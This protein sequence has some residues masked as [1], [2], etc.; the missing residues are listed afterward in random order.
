MDGFGERLRAAR[1][2]LGLTQTDLAHRTGVSVRAIRDLENGRVRT[3]HPHTEQ[4]L[5]AATGLFGAPPEVVELSV[6]ALGP[7]VVERRGQPV[8]PG[9]PMHALVL[10]V[11][12]LQPGEPI[13]QDELVDVLWG[14]NPPP[15]CVNLLHTYVSRL[16]QRLGG[17][18][19][20]RD[21]S[22]YVLSP[23]AS[24]VLEFAG[25]VRRASAAEGDRTTVHDLT[26]AALA[27]W[28]GEVLAGSHER[29]RWHPAAIAVAQ[30]RLSTA[31]LNAATATTPREHAAVAAR[32]LPLS[33]VEPLHEELHAA[34]IR[35]LS[36]SGQRALAATC[37]TDIS[38]RL[39]AELDVA[40]GVVLRA[41]HT[42]LYSGPAAL[43]VPAARRTPAQLPPLTVGFTGREAD[44][45]AM[46]EMRAEFVAQG[47]TAVLLVVGTPGVGKTAMAV[48]WA[49]HQQAAHPDGSLHVDLRGHSGGEPVTAHDALAGLLRALGATPQEVPDA[50]EERAGLY[51]TLLAE[52]RVLVVLDNAATADQVRPLLPGAPASTV[53]VTSRNR[54][55][56]LL[57]RDGARVLVLD[58]LTPAAARAVLA[59]QL[60]TARAAAEPAAVADLAERCAR[61][62]LALRISAA[63][64][65]SRPHLSVAEHAE[66]L[67]GVASLDALAIDDDEDA[68]VRASFTLSY[69]RLR[70]PVRAV[71]RLLGILPGPDLT[72]ATVAAAQGAEVRH[73]ASALDLLESAHLVHQRSAGRYS[74]HDLLRL[75]AA[76]RC[77]DEDSAEHRHDAHRRVLLHSLAHVH[78][79]RAVL[80]RSMAVLPGAEPHLA[81]APEF[82]DGDRARAWL[83]AERP[84]LVAA[85]TGLH[86]DHPELVCALTDVLRGHFTMG[87][88]LS[89]WARAAN[90]ALSAAERTGDAAA[91]AALQLSLGDLSR[92]RG[93]TSAALTHLHAALALVRR[94]PW[95]LGEAAVLNNMGIVFLKNGELEH[96]AA[97]FEAA[98]RIFERDGEPQAQMSPLGNLG[99]VLRDSGRLRAAVEICTRS[100]E[101]QLRLGSRFGQGVAAAN[102][103][104][105]LS[106]V[107]ELD[108]A[109]E[110]LL[111]GLRLSESHGDLG[112]EGECSRRLAVVRRRAGDLPEALRLAEH[113]FSLA[114]RVGDAIDVAFAL[115]TLG[116]VFLALGR[117]EDATGA[118]TRALAVAEEAG[119]PYATCEALTGL[120]FSTADPDPA[121]AA[122]HLT[123]KSGFRDLAGSALAALAHAHLRAGALTDAARYARDAVEVHRATG[124]RYAQARAAEV[125]ERAR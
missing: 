35:A 77:A 123:R 49:H 70:A 96:A 41:A 62:P 27:R 11:L 79:A 32:L 37:Y 29:L 75:Y 47:V 33:T 105:A 45:T 31:L 6:G 38:A 44:M 97:H 80:Y 26:T 103:G 112:T 115:N 114:E 56:G 98:L 118:H 83:D 51:R 2:R 24:D 100:R 117:T 42:A 22:G 121:S 78:Q 64:L 92:L 119:N 69:R 82:A 15:S 48:Q 40:P 36:S 88:H 108:R 7:L 101:L 113:A 116:T 10:G 111:D 4:V 46:D 63:I 8:D 86:E 57:A 106:E 122:L 53:V 5:A 95:T 25:L 91:Q 120:S 54:L 30:R 73:A 90:A 107:G 102:L 55:G 125:L 14:E 59:R 110:V 52:R 76:A 1:R 12:A 71:F 81:A 23:D 3:P 9:P 94:T 68:A 20:V 109:R 16:R 66:T 50:P 21:R 39:R 93:N 72:A 74:L 17:A 58:V 28:R 18:A 13:S 89:D 67:T 19:L 104:E 60:G 65:R 43:D 99:L 84:G 87:A 85:V 34:L 61:L 124:N